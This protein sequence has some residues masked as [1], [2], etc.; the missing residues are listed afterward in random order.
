MWAAAVLPSITTDFTDMRQ[1]LFGR[2]A[3][4]SDGEAGGH[5]LG[6]W[7][8][9][10]RM[11]SGLWRHVDGVA[12]ALLETGGAP[13]T[14]I[15]FDPIEPA[16]PQLDDRLLGTC[17]VAVVA[18]E[19]VA[20]GETPRRLIARLALRQPRH[21][22]VE[23]R[24]LRH[25]QLGVLAPIGIEEQRQVEQLV[26]DRRMLRRLLVDPAPQP[27]IDVARRL[28]AVADRRGHGARA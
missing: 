12:R 25:R 28:L 7:K 22:F 16:L 5:P 2:R 3:L 19:A 20:A 10:R 27:R 21:D 9:A 26:R 8:L 6:R 24:A 4:G 23:S 15:E 13:G 14:E 1:L 11:R 17:S 18:L